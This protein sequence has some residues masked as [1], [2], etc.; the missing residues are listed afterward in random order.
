[1]ALPGLAPVAAR[2]APPAVPVAAATPT[3]PPEARKQPMRF[4][5]HKR[6]EGAPGLVFA[7]G[8]VT[9]DTPAAFERLAGSHD[10]RGATMVLNSVGG[11]V[12]DTLTLGRRWR[13]LGVVTTVGA[14]AGAGGSDS[15]AVGIRPEAACESMCAFL[16]LAG[17]SR[18]VPAGAHVRVHQ[19]WLGDRVGD[20]QDASYS[21]Q[22]MTIVQR[23]V[24][25]LAQYTFEMGGS[26]ALLSLALSV[27]PWEP[28]HE[29]SSDELISAG[30]VTRDGDF[31]AAPPNAAPK[32]V[33]DRLA[34]GGEGAAARLGE[35]AEPAAATGGVA[36]AATAA[37][38]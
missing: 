9:A 36:R 1:M 32:L 10:L 30:L 15:K 2:A 26:G 16:L 35:A 28:L 27:P 3:T 37:Q 18:H 31:I 34:G 14:M 38:H 33:Q 23:D 22:D 24:G 11:S 19:I 4:S 12:L 20:A 29:L 17:T 5:W 7:V 8:S 13:E 6:G 25:R 21:A